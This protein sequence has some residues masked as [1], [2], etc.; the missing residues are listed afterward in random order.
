M[1]NAPD[2][3]PKACGCGHS[4]CCACKVIGAIVILALVAGLGFCAGTQH[5]QTRL[6]A[7]HGTTL[8]TQID[9]ARIPTLK[10]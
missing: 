10:P 6:G 7:R 9:A 3:P 2:S 5:G 1:D 4:N 8:T